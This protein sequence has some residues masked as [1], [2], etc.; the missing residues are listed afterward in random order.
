MKQ[1]WLCSYYVP[2]LCAT[3]MCTMLFNILKVIFWSVIFFIVYMKSIYNFCRLLFEVLQKTDAKKELDIHTVYQGKHQ[4][5]VKERERE[6]RRDRWGKLQPKKGEGEGRKNLSLQFKFWEG[7]SHLGKLG[8]HNKY[9]CYCSC[10]SDRNG[11]ALIS[12]RC[13]VIG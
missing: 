8:T 3:I 1:L 5:R 7:K 6:R 9:C 10:V 13:S 11:P 12:L 2:L 4:W